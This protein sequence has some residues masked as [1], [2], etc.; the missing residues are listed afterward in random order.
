MENK[1][2][3]SCCTESITCLSDGIWCVRTI[4]DGKHMTLLSENIED[5]PE[6]MEYAKLLEAKNAITNVIYEFVYKK[7]AL[8]KSSVKILTE[9]IFKELK[10]NK[11]YLNTKVT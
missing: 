11:I 10:T 4:K 2:S 1:H 5:Y 8:D 7:D 3:C 9:L 6:S